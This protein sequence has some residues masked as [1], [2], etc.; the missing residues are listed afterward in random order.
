MKAALLFLLL[1][2]VSAVN[3][4][5]CQPDAERLC[6]SAI[7]DGLFAIKACLGAHRDKLSKACLAAVEGH[8]Q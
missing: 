8:R 4:H 1:L 6:A 3:Q 5:A 7:P 2:E